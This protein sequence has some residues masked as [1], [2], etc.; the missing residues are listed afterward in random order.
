MP[1]V[2][3]MMRSPPQGTALNGRIAHDAE[4]KLPL[5]I[6]LECFMR[7]IPVVKTGYG[8]HADEVEGQRYDDR[9]P[10]PTDPKYAQTTEME[11]YERYDPQPIDL[12]LGSFGL[13][14]GTCFS[15]EPAHESNEN[16]RFQQAFIHT[17]HFKQAT[18]FALSIDI[19]MKQR[20]NQR[21]DGFL[22]ENFTSVSKANRFLALNHIR[23][24]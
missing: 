11:K 19:N 4:H 18:S 17:M 10:A 14:I 1:M 7:E 5:P 20:K 13:G 12:F 15:V 22:R 21:S 8:K 9:G 16:S 3:A 2:V 24:R 23:A 6:C